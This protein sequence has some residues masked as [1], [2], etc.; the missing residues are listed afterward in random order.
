MATS[1]PFLLLCLPQ[2][3]RVVSIVAVSETVLILVNWTAILW[4]LFDIRLAMRAVTG[5]AA[6]GSG[7]PDVAGIVA[8]PPLIFLGFPV[9]ATVLEAI[10]PFPTPVRHSLAAI[11]RVSRSR[12]AASS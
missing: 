11:W 3:E 6:V 12:R 9:A 5:G 4:M 7:A 10:L 1:S 2:P 8:L